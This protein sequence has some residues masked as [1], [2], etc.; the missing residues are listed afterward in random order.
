MRDITEPA[1]EQHEQRFYKTRLLYGN[2]DVE[3]LRHAH[4]CVVG[5]G[6]VGSWAVE[7]F[8]RTGIGELTLIDMDEVCITNTNRQIHANSETVGQRKVEVMAE[9]VR[10]IN[11]EIRV[12]TI[13]DFVTP[14]NIGNYISK[15]FD[16]V[17]DA[18]DSLKSKA[19]LIAYC[20]R[21]KIK[22]MT[23]GG[24]GGQVD[25]TQVKIADLSRTI[26]D[27]LAKKLKDLLR[28]NYNFSKNPDRKFGI[29]CV[30]STEQ[31]KYAPYDKETEEPKG[32]G[33]AVAVTG[34]FGFNAAARI[35][36]KI[37]ERHRDT[38]K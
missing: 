18:I 4:V 14:E 6:G 8:A 37:L 21:N 9:R 36:K 29:E 32:F 33:T 34:T 19:A 27:P 35:T 22:I 12:N 38:V 31:L 28:Q 1:S 10:L 13:D 3:I 20:K 11:P 7:A 16:Y 23:S 30:F 24:A 5:V 17:L 26:Q 25:P 15:D 2:S